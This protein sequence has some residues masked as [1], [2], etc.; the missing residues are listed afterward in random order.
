MGTVFAGI[1]AIVL[2]A[3]PLFW[4]WPKLLFTKRRKTSFFRSLILLIIAC[5]LAV[6]FAEPVNYLERFHQQMNAREFAKSCESYNKL[7]KSKQDPALLQELKRTSLAYAQDLIRQQQFVEAQNALTDVNSCLNDTKITAMVTELSSQ[8]QQQQEQRMVEDQLKDN[9]FL[10]IDNSEQRWQLVKLIYLDGGQELSVN[11]SPNAYQ[12]VFNNVSHIPDL[13]CFVSARENILI[14]KA[15]SVNVEPSR[16]FAIKADYTYKFREENG[17]QKEV[18]LDRL[19]LCIVTA[20]EWKDELDN[21]VIKDPKDISLDLIVP[22]KEILVSGGEQLSKSQLD[23]IYN[24]YDRGGRS[25]DFVI[26]KK[27]NDRS[28]L[29]HFLPKPDHLKCRYINRYAEFKKEYDLSFS[30]DEMEV[31]DRIHQSKL[32]VVN[33]G[34]EKECLISSVYKQGVLSGRLYGKGDR[35]ATIRIRD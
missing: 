13:P 5:I 17:E 23:Y 12:I 27:S 33:N 22:R 11:F 29:A 28:D 7:E 25:Y 21:D 20:G 8:A 3:T 2:L 4:I 1:F 9:K 24:R 32:P 18:L 16:Y 31:I 19:P 26:T 15:S 10:A 34:G 14:D 6:V 35:Y 30:K